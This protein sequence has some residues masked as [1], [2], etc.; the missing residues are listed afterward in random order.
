MQRRAV[1]DPRARLRTTSVLASERS[2]LLAYVISET[3][4]VCSDLWLS[5]WATPPEEADGWYPK[6]PPPFGQDLNDYFLWI[7]VI[8]GLGY[9]LLTLVRNG[10]VAAASACGRR[11]RAR[12]S[13]RGS[14]RPTWPPVRAS[15]VMTSVAGTYAGRELHQGLA[16][17]I[18]RAPIAFFDVTPIGRILNRFTKARARTALSRLP[19]PSC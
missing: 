11:D 9:S 18:L 5:L 1:P 19:R 3:V 7:Y 12:T 13:S 17:N 14:R 16:T 6:D 10:T 4:R 2:T 15:A 8:F